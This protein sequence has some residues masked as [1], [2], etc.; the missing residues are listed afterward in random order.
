MNR[1]RG[2]LGTLLGL[3]ILLCVAAAYVFA[4]VGTFLPLPWYWWV[5][6]IAVLVLFG[7]AELLFGPSADAK[8]LRT[9]LAYTGLMLVLLGLLWFLWWLVFR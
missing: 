5:V 9:S 8:G 6:A 1:F 7:G 4:D 2:A 3:A